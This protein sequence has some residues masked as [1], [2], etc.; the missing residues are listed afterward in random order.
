MVKYIPGTKIPVQ[1]SSST[2]IGTQLVSGQQQANTASQ[3]TGKPVSY[4]GGTFSSGGSSSGVSQTYA[5]TP[6]E[7][8]KRSAIT[9]ESI[10]IPEFPN[11]LK[12]AIDKGNYVAQ[13]ARIMSQKTNT[14][15]LDVL[16]RKRNKQFSELQS[17]A[18][19][20]QTEVTEYNK[21]G[22]LIEAKAK[23]LQDE[24]SRLNTRN[25]SQVASFNAKVN[26]FNQEVS[27]YSS[28]GQELQ[29][30][31]QQIQQRS[32]EAQ[33][34]AKKFE[35]L[36]LTQPGTQGPKPEFQS[37]R[38]ALNKN[39]GSLVSLVKSQDTK[40]PSDVSVPLRQVGR[41]TTDVLTSF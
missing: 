15:A 29:V 31:A 13:I 7:A 39:Q 24:A 3:I 5:V 14:S 32:F 35:T 27:A 10:K 2:I 22:A 30:K 11:T 19:Q 8:V 26:A 23:A 37:V 6:L 33:Q 25:P 21:Q 9:G 36:S 16:A 41:T 28:R 20:T 40:T 12:G 18:K 34:Q 17:E 1:G 38:N 4:S